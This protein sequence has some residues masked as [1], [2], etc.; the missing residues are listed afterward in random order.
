MNNLQPLATEQPLIVTLNPG[1]EPD[2]ALVYDDHLFEH[3]V[4]DEKAVSSQSA[5]DSIQGQDR[6]WFCGAYQRYG[7]HEDGLLSAVTMAKKM[8]IDP[9]W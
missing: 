5:I 4:F 7:F 3:P 6:L 9:P 1:H 8:G 2:P